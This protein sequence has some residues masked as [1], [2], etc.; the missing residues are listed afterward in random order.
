MNVL[1]NFYVERCVCRDSYYSKIMSSLSFFQ[2]SIILQDLWC[3]IYQQGH[4]HSVW[5]FSILS[6]TDTCSP[7]SIPQFPSI[8][9]KS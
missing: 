1:T 8:L 6:L 3:I 5:I 2:P 4:M 9:M 7:P